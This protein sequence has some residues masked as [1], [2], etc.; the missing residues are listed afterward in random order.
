MNKRKSPIVKPIC[1]KQFISNH[2][3]NK[4][5]IKVY[6]HYL[7]KKTKV[8]TDF[9]IQVLS[10][11]R[12]F[13]PNHFNVSSVMIMVDRLKSNNSL[14]EISKELGFSRKSIVSNFNKLMKFNDVKHF[15]KRQRCNNCG[16]YFQQI[17]WLNIKNWF[18]SRNQA[19]QHR[20]F[21]Q[22]Q[23]M[24]N[25]YKDFFVY[26]NEVTKN[27][28]KNKFKKVSVRAIKTSIFNIRLNFIE[29]NPNSYITSE[30]SIYHLLK[31]P[32]LNLPIDILPIVSK[33]GYSSVLSRKQVQ[34]KKKIGLNIKYRSEEINLRQ[35]FFDYEMDTV[36]GS[37]R[38]KTV[39]LTLLNRK[40]RKA[41]SI[42]IGRTALAAKEGLETLIKAFNLRIDSLTI[43]NGS[44]NYLLDKIDCIGQIY[45]CDPY[46]SSQKGSIENM[47]REIRLFF[48]KGKTFDNTSQEEIQ[49][50]MN[51]INNKTR[52]SLKYNGK[53]LSPNEYER[54]LF[55]QSC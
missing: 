10:S 3:N 19:E 1:I 13:D 17:Q 42:K 50:I 26:L 35:N 21:L 46:R 51:R 20:N 24:K 49:E 11:K 44:E 15:P 22:K 39:L 7:F 28:N 43:D 9:Y 48:P 14:K 47:H 31:L 2:L 8:D 45:H 37:K 34:K 25:R 38:S 29:S 5:N 40:S 33:R 27:Y 32:Y 30:Q 54:I 6:K 53:Y 18:D 23:I 52:K 12:K 55:A 36:V 41:Y 4:Q 16:Q